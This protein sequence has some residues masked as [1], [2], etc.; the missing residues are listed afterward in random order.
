MVTA[1]KKH[2]MHQAILWDLRCMRSGFGSQIFSTMRSEPCGA[3]GTAHRDAF[4]KVRK[5]V[6]FQFPSLLI[7]MLRKI[8]S[9]DP[10]RQVGQVAGRECACL[11]MYLSSDHARASP[12]N[13]S[14]GPVYKAYVCCLPPLK[15]RMRRTVS[16]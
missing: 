13:N 5:C 7:L 1:N 16:T 12:G 10:G 2:E 6:N 3:F 11:Q 4:R 15:H 8:S 9:A 14:Q